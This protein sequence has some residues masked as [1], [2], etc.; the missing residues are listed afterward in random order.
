M[1][2]PAAYAKLFAE[3]ETSA[4]RIRGLVNDG[5]RV[6]RGVPYG[7]DTAGPARFQPASPHPGWAGTRDCFRPGAVAP[8]VPTPVGH[9]YAR[10]IQFDFAPAEG[11]IGEDCLTLNVFAPQSDGEKRPIMVCLH[12][13]GFAIGTGNAALY[14]GTLLAL[15]QNVVVVAINHRLAAFGF[16][17]LRG[18]GADERFDAAGVAGML[19]IVLALEWIRDNAAA[20]GGDAERVTLFG[21]S[22][23]GWKVSTLLAMPGA[24]GL[25]HRAIV[26]SGSWTVFQSDETAAAL[27]AA[28]LAQLGLTPAD[29][30]RLLEIDMAALLAA[31]ASVGALAFTPVVHPEFLPHQPDDPRAIAFSAGVPLLIST[32]RDDAG[33]FFHHFD[34]DEAGLMALLEAQYGEEAG[35][36]HALY[37]AHRPDKSPYLLHAEI[38][39]DAGFRRF[40]HV[41]A[42]ARHR[43]GA[44]PVRLSRW[45]WPSPAWDGRFGAAHA[46]D[47]SASFAHPHAPL[48]GAGTATGRRLAARLSSTFARFAATGTPGED[49]PDW[50]PDNRRCLLLDEQDRVVADPDRDLRLYWEG[51]PMAASVLG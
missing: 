28:L 8:Q 43:A 33:L 31:Q 19:D 47:V 35:A 36:I 38:V 44:A 17:G 5:I 4:G 40:A 2:T 24:R 49:W 21:Q 51:R 42:M 41:Q 29:W 39:T 34:C 20:F 30:P 48:L 37:R 12:G 18:L 16:A 32:M 11:G 7:S 25:F 22:G 9:V 26:Q 14:D 27:T 50:T 6:F 3:I 23:G 13:G 10:L 45:D 15:E 46:M 1:Q